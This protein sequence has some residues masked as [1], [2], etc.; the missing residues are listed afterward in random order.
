MAKFDP[1]HST[2]FFR[3]MT[4]TPPAFGRLAL[5]PNLI[6]RV[7]DRLLGA[8]V[9]GSLAPGERVMQDELASRLGVSRQPVSHALHAL[10][11]R[12]LVSEHGRRGFQITPI[13]AA[14]IRDL[15]EVRQALDALA[16]AAAARRVASRQLSKTERQT[17]ERSLASGLALD[18]TAPPTEWIEAD[19]AFH[20]A[21]HA[22]SGNVAISETVAEQWPHFMR[23]MRL[24]L[25]HSDVRAR[26]WREHAGIVEAILA[27]DAGLAADRAREHA[28]LA[29]AETAERM[30]AARSVA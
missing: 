5:A 25:A 27:G 6:D 22:L 16:A 28:A 3:V 23:S 9:E 12:G 30:Q 11:R 4:A 10:K 18:D 29:A 21:V 8:I 7:Y 2:G 17:L 1:L 15:Y 14:R 13:D 24:V 20:S 19:V 26:V